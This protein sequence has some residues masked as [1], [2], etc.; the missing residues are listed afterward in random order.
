MVP[1]VRNLPFSALRLLIQLTRQPPPEAK[2][3]GRMLK[4]DQGEKPPS[5][6][7]IESRALIAYAT[8]VAT[9]SLRQ[10]V[11]G[12]GVMINGLCC[13]YFGAER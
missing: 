3:E 7:R 4:W 5:R 10:T 2:L 8:R 1:W 13:F 6:F 11:L 9:F 12:P